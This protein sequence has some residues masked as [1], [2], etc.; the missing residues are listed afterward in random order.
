[1]EDGPGAAAG[2]VSAD[3]SLQPPPL[4]KTKTEHITDTPPFSLSQPL[5]AQP[6]EELPSASTHT[7]PKKRNFDQFEP[8]PGSSNNANCGSCANARGLCGLEHNVGR[9]PGAVGWMVRTRAPLRT[10]S[11]RDGN[12]CC[13]ERVLQAAPGFNGTCPHAT[14][15]YMHA[16]HR[17]GGCLG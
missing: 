11:E 9:L 8:A 13:Q 5:A 6:K 4:K 1:M 10:T 15:D 17:A 14:Q 7:E 3:E 12:S 2:R 16:V